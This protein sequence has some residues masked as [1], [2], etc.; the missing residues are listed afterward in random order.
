[1]NVTSSP[2]SRP[3]RSATRPRPIV[4][5]M[6]DEVGQAGS[7]LSAAPDGRS[8]SMRGPAPERRDQA[9]DE[10]QPERRWSTLARPPRTFIERSRSRRRPLTEQQGRWPTSQDGPDPAARAGCRARAGASTESAST[11]G[12][13]QQPS[14]RSPSAAADRREA[15]REIA[16]VRRRR[17]SRRAAPTRTSTTADQGHEWRRRRSA[18]GRA[19]ALPGQR[20]GAAEPWPWRSCAIRHLLAEQARGRNTSTRIRTTNAQTSFRPSRCREVLH[21]HDLDDAEDQA[22]ERRRRGCCRCR[23]AR[24]R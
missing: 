21:G 18:L 9:A 2:E 4:T 10:H 3:H 6:I 17:R 19:P 16:G 8:A 23:R 11:E 20:S 13:E 24:P 12:D 7:G 5:A 22:A 15:D 14:R 1:M